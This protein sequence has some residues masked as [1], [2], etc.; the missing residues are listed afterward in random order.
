MREVTE[1]AEILE[2]IQKNKMS[3]IYFSG[4]SCGACEVIKNKV[5]KILIEYPSIECAEV[6][7]VINNALASHYSIFSLPILLLF[8]DGKETI[9]VGRNFNIL[10][11]N[12]TIE[13]YYMMLF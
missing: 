13:R 8:V 6:N 2:I 7:G 5:E 9:R 3:I 12:K 10:D 1:K 4:T 11:F